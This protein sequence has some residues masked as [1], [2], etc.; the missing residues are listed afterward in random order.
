MIRYFFFDNMI[1]NGIKY[2]IGKWYRL[3]LK[4]DDSKHKNINN[5]L[6]KYN[7]DFNFRLSSSDQPICSNIYEVNV[8][9]KDNSFKILKEIN[10]NQL[11]SDFEYTEYK[12]YNA[13]LLVAIKKNDKEFLKYRK[14]ETKINYHNYKILD[15]MTDKELFALYKIGKDV[16]K[17][18]I[19]DK[20]IKEIILFHYY[21]CFFNRLPNNL[22]P[23]IGYKGLS[24]IQNRHKGEIIISDNEQ[25]LNEN[26]NDYKKIFNLHY[27]QFKNLISIGRKKDI[28]FLKNKELDFDKTKLLIENIYNLKYLK[29][30]EQS[31]AFGFSSIAKF[32]IIKNDLDR[33]NI[34]FIYY[35]QI[36]KSKILK[37]E[38]SDFLNEI[39]INFFII[40]T[41]KKKL[42]NT[43]F[44]FFL[45]DNENDL[46]IDFY[47]KWESKL[48]QKLNADEYVNLLNDIKQLQVKYNYL[49]D[50]DFCD[51]N[52]S[53]EDLKYLL[54]KE[55]KSNNI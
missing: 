20:G 15:I 21:E 4:Y 45:L 9:K 24:K 6:L 37:I 43:G 47:I 46:A 30:I 52:Y 32:S 7:N 36:N 11:F 54:K 27:F 19:L 2:E 17:S 12:Y 23:N 42:N 41:N 29:E 10:Y 5:L 48:N 28:D 22:F 25:F 38:Y 49:Y 53:E 40:S 31:K 16:T 44:N 3:P 14:E 26:F 13:C 1:S 8:N 51:F 55:P 39:I 18:Y 50:N 33:K 34:R 35:F